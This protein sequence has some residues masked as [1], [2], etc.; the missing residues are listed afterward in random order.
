MLSPSD[1]RV[2]FDRLAEEHELAPGASAASNVADH[3]DRNVAQLLSCGDAGIVAEAIARL[4]DP[5]PVRRASP[6]HDR[7][8]GGYGRTFGL[9]TV[10]DKARFVL[11]HVLPP[12]LATSALADGAAAWW[13]R[14]GGRLRWDSASG[15]FR[16]G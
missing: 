3:Y 9:V 2:L 15:H 10:G 13:R 12:E 6:P 4:N 14:E 5:T 7:V 1:R 11:E 16:R 8:E